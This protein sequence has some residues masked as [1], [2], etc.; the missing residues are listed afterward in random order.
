M[1]RRDQGA[2]HFA[3]HYP[4]LS[5]NTDADGSYGRYRLSRALFC[6]TEWSAEFFSKRP[7]F[8]FNCSQPAFEVWQQLLRCRCRCVEPLLLPL[9]NKLALPPYCLS[10]SQQALLRRFEA[11]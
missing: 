8:P 3:L 6:H 5:F 7:A 9:C 10:G 1:R 11:S 2:A 4:I